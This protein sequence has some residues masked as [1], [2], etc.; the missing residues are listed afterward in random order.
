MQSHTMGSTSN[1]F[2]HLAKSYTEYAFSQK[3]TFLALFYMRY[4]GEFDSDV[5]DLG[6]DVLISQ[7]SKV[8][9]IYLKTI[10]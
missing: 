10:V 9:I 5:V 3:F 7:M 8:K 6:I 1:Q 2:D 4:N